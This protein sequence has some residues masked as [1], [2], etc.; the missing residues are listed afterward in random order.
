MNIKH[1]TNIS[2]CE[3]KMHLEY[4]VKISFFSVKRNITYNTCK[5]T[6]TT[7]MRD[8]FV[9]TRVNSRRRG[10]SISYHL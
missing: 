2:V 10:R 4:H 8:K 1:I 9:Q 3:I 5:L 6:R 7:H